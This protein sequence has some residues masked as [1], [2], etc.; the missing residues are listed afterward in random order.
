M[1]VLPGHVIISENHQK[2]INEIVRKEEHD[3]SDINVP[4]FEL[5]LGIGHVVR[6]V[7]A[8]VAHHQHKEPIRQL[9]NVFVKGV[10]WLHND[11]PAKDQQVQMG[12]KENLQNKVK[13]HARD[14][15]CHQESVGQEHE[16]VVHCL[17]L[18]VFLNVGEEGSVL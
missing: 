2:L 6:K 5:Y 9:Q 18:V 4:N 8:E 7:K 11:E 16:W 10:H 13:T 15:D 14:Y 1:L 12:Q 17:W 3:D